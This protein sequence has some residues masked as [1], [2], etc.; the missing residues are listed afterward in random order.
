M[1]C[2]LLCILK[3][4][5]GTRNQEDVRGKHLPEYNYIFFKQLI[6][7][8]NKRNEYVCLLIEIYEWCCKSAITT[9]VQCVQNA[10]RIVFEHR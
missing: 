2:D 10:V 5:H 7:T 1:I 3:F 4:C 9:I 6:R 8:I